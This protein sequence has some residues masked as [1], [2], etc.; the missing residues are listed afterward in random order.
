VIVIACLL[1]ARDTRAEERER[2]REKQGA[3]ERKGTLLVGS[4]SAVRD[5]RDKGLTH[6]ENESCIVLVVRAIVA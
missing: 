4:A 1:C 6:E 2:K 3:R 5:T